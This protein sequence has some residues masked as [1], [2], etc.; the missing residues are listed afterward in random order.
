MFSDS[1]NRNHCYGSVELHFKL[2]LRLNEAGVMI[3]TAEYSATIVLD[4]TR[5]QIFKE[6]EIHMNE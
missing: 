1:I 4:S 5:A 2:T 3:A 6:R